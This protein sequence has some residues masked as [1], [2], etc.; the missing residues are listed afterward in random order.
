V[1]PLIPGTPPETP[2]PVMPGAGV[3]GVVGLPCTGVVVVVGLPCDEP[4]DAEGWAGGVPVVCPDTSPVSEVAIAAAIAH[5]LLRSSDMEAPSMEDDGSARHRDSVVILSSRGLHRMSAFLPQRPGAPSGTRVGVAPTGFDVLAPLRP[6]FVP[7]NL[8]AAYATLLRKATMRIDFRLPHVIAGSLVAGSALF[9]SL[10]I[11][12]NEIH[13]CIDRG[14]VTYTD[15][16]CAHRG[17]IVVIAMAP[18]STTARKDGSI[19]GR[20]TSV[21]LGMSP[22]IVYEVMGRPRETI[23]TL[24]GRMLVEYWIYRGVESTTRIAFQEGRV[25]RIDAR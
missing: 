14:R 10:V 12:G 6:P 3:V 8:S 23:A 16:E 9:G 22:R 20:A 1:T 11:A 18:G 17:E 25:V 19:N 13:R 4:R 5:S 21:L 24:E 7:V 2:V 15:Q